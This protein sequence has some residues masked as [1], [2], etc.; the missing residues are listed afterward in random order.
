MRSLSAVSCR[1]KC[2]E[3]NAFTYRCHNAS[4]GSNISHDLCHPP[5]S[6]ILH[7]LFKQFVGIRSTAV[8]KESSV[9][10][11]VYFIALV[12]KQ[13]QLQGTLV[14]PRVWGGKA[15]VDTNE[16]TAR[17]WIQG[18][19][20]TSRDNWGNKKR[21]PAIATATVPP[22]TPWM[23]KPRWSRSSFHHFVWVTC[24]FLSH[25]VGWFLITSAVRLDAL[26]KVC[27]C[28]KDGQEKVVTNA[29]S[30]SAS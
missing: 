20:T 22:Q 10:I 26:V 27:N 29:D 14:P 25:C 5:R 16:V 13:A 24:N 6:I 17:R 18:E 15:N 19:Q 8:Y 9:L 12:H 1:T 3:S 2:K 11:C 21:I 23:P 30:F 4:T 28:P 7:K